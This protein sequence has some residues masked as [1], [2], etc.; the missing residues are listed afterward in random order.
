[1]D[2]T[3][4]SKGGRPPSDI[5]AAQLEGLARLN[6]TIEEA[7]AFFKVSKRTLLR[8]LKKKEMAEAWERGKQGGRLSLRRLQWQHANGTGSSA[9]QM[10]IHLSKHWLGET[11]KIE[12]NTHNTNFV[13][14]APAPMAVED[15][16]RTFGKG[17]VAPAVLPPDD[18]EDED[19]PA[20]E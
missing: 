12:Q 20:D 7:A 16:K 9:V 3:T 14:E 15:W 1:M 4:P 10:T 13:V 6:A 18:N 8:H 11:D 2:E 5:P 19:E 17:D